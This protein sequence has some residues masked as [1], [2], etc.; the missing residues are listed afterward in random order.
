MDDIEEFL[1]AWIPLFVAID[2]VGLVPIFLGITQGIDPD[3]RRKIAHQAT[4]T[5]GVV[6]VGFMFL[7]K[8]I[9]KALGISIADFQIGG[10][11]ILF[12]LA[13]RDVLGYSEKDLVTRED[14]AIVP[15]GLPLITGPAT[16]V[17]VLYLMDA[18]GISATLLALLV[19][20]LLVAMGFQYGERITRW[21]GVAGLRA[22]SKII[23][24]L[25]AAIAVSM[26]VRGWLQMSPS[27]RI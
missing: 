26:V 23:A 25:L 5:A 9:F 19:N 3:R 18:V 2:P 6:A 7:G 20:L 15:L 4:I 16:L 27:M 24:L 13:T 22:V 14:V 17:A 8:F 1:M 11:L 12:I 10:G 21:M